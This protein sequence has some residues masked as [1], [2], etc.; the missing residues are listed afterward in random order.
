MAAA[1]ERYKDGELTLGKAA[2]IADEGLIEFKEMLANL[3]VKRIITTSKSDIRKAD[4]LLDQM[5]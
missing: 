1:I 2:E 5:R 4:E 3:G